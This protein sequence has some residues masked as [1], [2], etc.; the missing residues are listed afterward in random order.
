MEALT[1]EALDLTE[2]QDETLTTSMANKMGWNNDPI[3]EEGILHIEFGD[4]S[5][6]LYQ[7]VSRTVALD[8]LNRAMNPDN[9]EETFA[10]YFHNNIRT[11]YRYKRLD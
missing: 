3:G 7:E 5:R 2:A 10:Q 4:G 6:Y 8:I 11:E 1:H 9:Y